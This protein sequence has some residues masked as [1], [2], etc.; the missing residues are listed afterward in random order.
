LAARKELPFDRMKLLTV[1]IASRLD[2]DKEFE[3]SQRWLAR[4]AEKLKDLYADWLPMDAESIDILQLTKIP[5]RAY[6]S[7]EEKLAVM[8]ESKTD[9][10]SLR[11]SYSIL[12]TLLVGEFKDVDKL[13]KG[14]DQYVNVHSIV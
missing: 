7:F 12:G 2:V 13:L 9:R 14:R 8:E 5:Y 11:D 6:F 3:L 1:P 4:A 10:T